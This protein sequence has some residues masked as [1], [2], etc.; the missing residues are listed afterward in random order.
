MI[1]HQNKYN[2]ILY[3][4]FESI[5]YKA[6][7]KAEL[8]NLAYGFQSI[9]LDSSSIKLKFTMIQ[10]QLMLDGTKPKLKASKP[11]RVLLDSIDKYQRSISTMA[12]KSNYDM[13]SSL[14]ESENHNKIRIY[15]YL[16]TI[17]ESAQP[18]LDNKGNLRPS[19]KNT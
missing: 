3:E 17:K 18:F 7:F 15:D 4:D 5:F 16:F 1:V 19:I 14:N 2:V 11:A 9:D 6:I 12:N 10:R 13:E 8:L